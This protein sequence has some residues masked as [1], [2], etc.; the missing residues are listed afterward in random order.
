MA[1]IITP[2]AACH[3][4]DKNKPRQ[5]RRPSHIDIKDA[6]ISEVFFFPILLL[7]FTIRC[8]MVF[9]LAFCCHSA[10]RIELCDAQKSLLKK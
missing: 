9:W 8:A 4:L 6:A 2:A 10:M 7:G 1:T 5:P 3:V